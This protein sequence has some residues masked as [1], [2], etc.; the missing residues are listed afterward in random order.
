M[1]KAG[2]GQAKQWKRRNSRK[3]T[4]LHQWKLHSISM[5]HGDIHEGI[6]H[7]NDKDIAGILELAGVD[8]ARNMGL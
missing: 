6:V 3:S 4:E 1:M 2:V 5:E 7:G 8:V